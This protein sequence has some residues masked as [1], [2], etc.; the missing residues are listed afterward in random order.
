MDSIRTNAN[1]KLLTELYSDNNENFSANINASREKLLTPDKTIPSKQ[2]KP[3]LNGGRFSIN[4]DGAVFECLFAVNPGKYLYVVYNGA[5]YGDKVNYTPKFP[6]WSYYP[7]LNGCYLGI[8]DP[9][10]WMGTDIELAWFYG[11]KE[12]SYIADSLKIVHAVCE[13]KNIPSENVIF[14]SSSGGG[15]T[16]IYAS[17]LWRHSLSISIN[18][19]I[20]IQN[21]QYARDFTRITGIDLTEEDPL[22][23]NDLFSHIHEHPLSHHV[24][25]VNAESVD[26][27][28]QQVIPFAKECNINLRYG[29]NRYKN[30]LIWIYQAKYTSPHKAFETQSIF[31]AIE[32]IARK[33]QEGWGEGIP[34]SM[35]YLAVLINESWR[36]YYERCNDLS[37]LKNKIRNQKDIDVDFNDDPDEKDV[38]SFS[39]DN[40]FEEIT[41]TPIEKNWNF[42]RYNNFKPYTEYLIVLEDVIPVTEL[43]KF[44]I[45]LYDFKKEKVIKFMEYSFD[46]KIVLNFSLGE[47][48]D[49]LGLVIYAG[50]AGKTKNQSIS[51]GRLCIYSH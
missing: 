24:I 37:I 28:S 49:G 19:Q 18:P 14:F 9:T 27:F 45:G 26:D 25:V 33:F 32:F 21:W 12:R 6:R 16:G 47:Y 48:T 29:L 2:I 7:I 51:I 39:L 20:Y 15:Y 35:Q 36:D 46:N 1:I 50:I 13:A 4:I 3:L 30:I 5:K 42:F 31:L 10:Y 22:H 11:T 44:T 8:D 38:L 43:S 34:D 40:T 23:R 17:A 41:L